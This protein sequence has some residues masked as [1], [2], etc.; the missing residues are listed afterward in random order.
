MRDPGEPDVGNV[1]RGGIDPLQIPNGLFG[2][3]KY[4]G[5]EAAAVLRREYPRVSPFLALKWPDIQNIH[6]ED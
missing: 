3:G 6:N 1:A 4:V 5:Q 2:F